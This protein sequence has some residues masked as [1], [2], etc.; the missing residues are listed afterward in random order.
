MIILIQKTSL[1]MIIDGKIVSKKIME[2]IKE[3]LKNG[4]KIMV[5]AIAYKEDKESIVYFNSIK[6]NAEKA[7]I[8]FNLL[9]IEGKDLI[10]KINEL[11]DDSSVTGIIVGR[12]FP[13]GITNEIVSLAL[14]P[15]KDIDC[16]TPHNLGLLNFNI[17]SIAPA[18]PKATIDIL[19][20]NGISLK[21]KNVLVINRSVTVGRPLV[22]LLLNRD[23]TVT[24]AHSKTSNMEKMIEDNDIIILA[25]GKA[26]YLKSSSIKG[27]KI[28]VDV[29][30]NVV[31]DRIVGDF[32]NDAQREDI[33]YTPVPGGV[34]SVTSAEIL[35]NALDIVNL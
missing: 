6:R 13:P 8:G 18:T 16:V 12:P 7:G 17:N 29:G 25:V 26:G 10:E 31:G 3:R 22:N 33:Y 11:N 14:N 34:G 23:A 9:E 27:K 5:A 32:E 15:D 35:K 1:Y 19:E 4:P 2:D 21:G 24:I 30:I 28:I 20:Q